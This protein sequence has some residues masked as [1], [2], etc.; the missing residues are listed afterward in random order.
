MCYPTTHVKKKNAKTVSFQV[1]N[2]W[3]D[4]WSKTGGLFS[5]PEELTSIL[6]KLYWS[7]THV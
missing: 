7:D 3:A 6:Q 2:K 5:N 4:K 1:L